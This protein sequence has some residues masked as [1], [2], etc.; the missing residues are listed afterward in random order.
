MRRLLAPL[1]LLLF[2]AFAGPAG[3]Q[4]LASARGG[5]NLAEQVCAACH[6]VGADAIS[7]RSLTGA[8]AFTSLANMPEMNAVSLSAFLI[9]PHPT[10]P[11][12]ML[13]SD[14]AADVIAY[15]M[16]LRQPR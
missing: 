8:P 12:L 16:S 6:A 15:I 1:G 7:D 10:M 11:D 4:E 5:Q 9:T 13:S 14:E 2:A 3:S